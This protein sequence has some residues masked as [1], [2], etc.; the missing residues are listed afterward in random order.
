MENVFM[1]LLFGFFG[2]LLLAILS[3]KNQSI[4]ALEKGKKR[5]KEMEINRC[6]EIVSQKF[7]E[8]RPSI[9]NVVHL[10]CD[11]TLTTPYMKKYCSRHALILLRFIYNPENNK[12]YLVLNK[13][14]YGEKA[15]F[16]FIDGCW[17]IK[18][19]EKLTLE[20]KAMRDILVKG[21]FPE[22]EFDGFNDM[23]R[24]LKKTDSFGVW[25]DYA[26]SHP[27]MIPDN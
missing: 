12:C 4:T 10:Y 8:M 1:G 18:T 7:D 9:R 27:L 6:K 22:K 26:V 24:I 11:Q 16:Q 5:N 14:K 13:N 3:K 2:V 15:L 21:G 25:L 19:E 17:I 23:N 20:E